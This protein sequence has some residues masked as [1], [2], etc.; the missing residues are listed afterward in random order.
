MKLSN[1][2]LIGSGFAASILAFGV[3]SGLISFKDA[4]IASL[5]G[6]PAALISHVATDSKAQTRLR[7]TESKL[8]KALR[9]LDTA[10]K[11]LTRLTELETKSHYLSLNLEETQKALDLAVEQHQ[12]AHDINQA[13][14]KQSSALEAQVAAFE[15]E[16]EEWEDEFS[17]RVEAAADAKFQV[18]KKAEIQKIFDEHDAITSQAMQLF[19]ELQQWGQKVAHGHQV[20]REII[21]EMASNYNQNLDEFA[22]A[23]RTEINGYVTQIELLNEKTARLQQKLNGDLIEPEYLECGFDQNGKI[24]NAIANWLWL[25]RQIPLKVTGF[26]S[27]SDNTLIAGFTYGRSMPQD[28]LVKQIERDSSDIARHL[29]L[30]A[31]EKP[32]K[33]Q[34]TDC[35][36]IN[37]KRERPAKKA[38]NGS[39]YRSKED[40]IKFVMAQRC[41][42]RLVGKPGAGKTPSL[43]VVL[44]HLLERGFLN[45][46]TPDGQKLAH[47]LI[48]F[49][50]PLEGISVKNGDETAIFHKWSDPKE[51]LKALQYE[52]K[53]RKDLANKNY[54]DTVGYLWCCDEFD[55][56]VAGMGKTELTNFM[57]T[58]RDGG[59]TNM[60]AIILGQSVMVS[61]SVAFTIEDQKFFTN[62]LL[63]SVSIR[64][65]LIEYGEKFYSSKAVEVALATLEAIE[66]EIE[67]TNEYICDTARQLRVA[68]VISDKS[69][70]FY[71]L[72][73]FDSVSIKPQQYQE[74]LV[75]INNLQATKHNTSVIEQMPKSFAVKELE[76]V[77]VGGCLAPMCS[78]CGKPLR[79]NGKTS[80]GTQKYCCKNSNCKK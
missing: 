57:K 1:G 31:I 25:N 21:K 65:F 30:Y 61:K 8:S 60:G 18:A 38:A 47:T 66:A 51:A 67:E 49:C 13:L 7:E 14:K 32:Q 78:K 35:L 39:L 69:P 42:F 41:F 77:V 6:L 74:S 9:D 36:T 44:S 79:R 2:L 46:N 59:H 58:L 33:L 54:K 11:S 75:V 3:T 72:P 34:V 12:K 37:I 24:A 80:S 4:S 76:Q 5:I 22:D 15:S 50:N 52:Y 55:N 29:G 53:F 70:V 43:M 48:E 17:D 40:F 19:Q 26:E 10:N 68:M 56:A 27:K 45:G 23:A 73:Y 71:H 20:K 63:D 28:A 64:T 62:I 16:V